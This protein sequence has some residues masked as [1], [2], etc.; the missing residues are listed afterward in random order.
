MAFSLLNEQS[1]D[2]RRQIERSFI[3]SGIS[4]WLVLG[5]FFVALFL[6]VIKRRNEVEILNETAKQHREVFKHYTITTLNS[7]ILISAVMVITT[8]SLYS[9][10]SSSQDWRLVITVPIIVY[11][12]FRQ[13]HLAYIGH[14]KNVSDN[15]L[16]DKGTAVAVLV[17]AVL[18][19]ILLYFFPDEFF[20]S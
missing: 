5:I 9:M 17:Y 10:N 4:P 19:F 13:I 11:V 12:V 20:V 7:I 18:T 2:K 15:I 6:A 14:D 1:F 8:Y 16:K 3:Q